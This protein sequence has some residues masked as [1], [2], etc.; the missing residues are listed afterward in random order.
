[1]HELTQNQRVI[2]IDGEECLVTCGQ[3]SKTRWV[4][5]G[6]CAGRNIQESGSSKE[7]AFKNWKQAALFMN[8]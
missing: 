8:N 7:V 5:I 6:N 3:R 2:T 1:M 4:A